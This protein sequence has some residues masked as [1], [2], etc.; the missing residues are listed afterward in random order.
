MSSQIVIEP[1]AAAADARGWVIEPVDETLLARQRNV[2]VV[3]TEPGA[4][5]GNHYHRHAT[6]VM[7]ATGPALVRWREA[8]ETREIMLAAG[9]ASRFT[10]PPGVPHASKN[11]GP[12][13]QILVSFS[14][15]PYD[16][17]HPDTVRDVLIPA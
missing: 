6:E 2:H 10:F 9:E 4:V 16:P 14:T 13:P 12:R 8:G 15:H 5:R 1:V 3:W 11:T 7:L 17:A